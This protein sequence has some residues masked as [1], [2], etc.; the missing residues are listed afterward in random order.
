VPFVLINGKLIPMGRISLT[1]MKKE[2]EKLV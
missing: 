1:R 2:V